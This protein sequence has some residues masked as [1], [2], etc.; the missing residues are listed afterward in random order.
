MNTSKTA[1]NDT[2]FYKGI[3]IKTG[4]QMPGFWARV[5]KWYEGGYR[6]QRTANNALQRRIDKALVSGIRIDQMGCWQ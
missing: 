6:T 4:F 1:M 2:C 3:A 5:G